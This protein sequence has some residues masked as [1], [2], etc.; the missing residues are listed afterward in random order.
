MHAR[1][2][3]VA[4]ALTVVF[5]LAG[6]AVCSEPP[7]ASTIAAQQQAL[8]AGNFADRQDFDFVSR[9]YLGTRAD[10]LIKTADGR[11]AWDLA[12]YDFLKGE[13]PASVEPGLWRQAQLLARHGLFEVTPGIYQVRGFDSANATFVRGHTGWIVID[14]LGFTETARAAYDLVTE[15][16]GHR[17]IAALVYTHGH[18]DHFAGGGGLIGAEDARSGKIKVVAPE[19]FVEQLAENTLAGPA[20]SRRGNYQFGGLLPR[21]P[22]GQVSA[23]IGPGIARGTSSLIAPNTIVS[24]TGETLS[25]DGVRLEFQLT[26]GT[27]S[28]AEMNIYLPD[29]RALCMAENANAT[30]HNVLTPR[31]S[32]VR[33]AKLWAD[34]LTRTLRLYGDKTDVMFASHAWPRFGRAVVVDYLGKHRDAYKFLHD[35]SVRLMNQGLTGPE[36]AERLILPPVLGREWYNH[37]F[38]GTM[39]FNSRAVYQRYLGWYDGNPVHLAPLPPEKAAKRYVEAMGGRVRV[40]EQAQAAFDAGD[41]AWAA[42]LLDK[43]VFSDASDEAAKALLARAYDQLGYQSESSLSRNMY[44]MG[45]RELRQGTGPAAAAGGSAGL[46]TSMPLSMML[47]V[48]AVRLDPAKVGD[49]RL[50]FAVR[51]TDTQESEY[52]VIANGVLVHEPIAPPGPVEASFILNRADFAGFAAGGTATLSAKMASGEVKIDG[53]PA[54][55]GKLA[56]WLDDRPGPPFGIVTP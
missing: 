21:G 32:L 3:N 5:S 53:N 11:T 52:V 38:Y 9:G 28:P 22:E 30:M 33:D 44:L 50:T 15:R 51:L 8:A 12:A 2:R 41:Y 6:R 16:L 48:I 20:M 26:P 46:L 47:D 19:G 25:L 31:G 18:V 56:G 43:L 34:E 37:G 17:P 13:V 4:A 39:S 14:T 42:E 45:A 1:D 23:G 10:P 27:E 35:Q 54:V 29:F 55:L 40:L 7:S 24:R 49:D 36:I